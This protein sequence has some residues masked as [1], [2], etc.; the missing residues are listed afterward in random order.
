VSIDLPTTAASPS[1]VGRVAPAATKPHICTASSAPTKERSPEPAIRLV[2]TPIVRS[3]AAIPTISRTTHGATR[4][5]LSL[6]IT[7]S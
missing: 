7:R 3:R 6:T 2:T 1:T 4:T 5:L